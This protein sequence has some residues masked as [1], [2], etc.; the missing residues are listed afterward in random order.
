MKL[1]FELKYHVKYY[2]YSIEFNFNSNYIHILI[3]YKF[4]ILFISK[5]VT[6]CNKYYIN[7]SIRIKINKC[8]IL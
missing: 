1:Y 3:L 5:L 4:I 8:I 2:I 7:I 6:L